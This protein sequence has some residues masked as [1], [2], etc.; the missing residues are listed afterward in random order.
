MNK[1]KLVAAL[2]IIALMVTSI[3][4]AFGAGGDETGSTDWPGNINISNSK[5]ETEKYTLGQVKEF[6]IGYYPESNGSWEVNRHVSISGAAEVANFE[7]YDNSQ[8]KDIGTFEKKIT[9][10][11]STVQ[12][13]RVA[14]NT[15]GKYTIRFWTTLDNGDIVKESKRNVYVSDDGI[16]VI[17]NS[18]I[19]LKESNN[20][21]EFE[22]GWSSGIDVVYNFYIDGE[23]INQSEIEQTRYDASAYFDKFTV[24][25]HTVSVTAVLVKTKSVPNGG[26]SQTIKSIKSKVESDPITIEY[27]VEDETTQEQT[28]IQPTTQPETS[29]ETTKEA[30]TTVQTTTEPETSKSPETTDNQTTETQSTEIQTTKPVQSETTTH[31]QVT[32]VNYNRPTKPNKISRPAKTKISSAVKKR[33]AKKAKIKIKRVSKAVGYEIQ[34]CRD[35]KFKKKNT[36]IKITKKLNIIVKKLKPNKKYYVRARAFAMNKKVKVYSIWSKKVKIKLKK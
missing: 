14:F 36:I 5:L 27:S 25:V 35:K 21:L 28:T 6:E 4:P 3:V 16:Y 22:W 13:L 1:K 11:T 31:Q 8:W 34:I 18:P 12:K 29:E 10:N 32:T 19:D 23:K 17:P 9:I 2:I 20:K 30:E 33:T 7:Y 15:E 24:G 26:G